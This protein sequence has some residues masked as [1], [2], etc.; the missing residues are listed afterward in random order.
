MGSIFPYA[1]D[2]ISALCDGGSFSRQLKTN[3]ATSERIQC[4]IYL[5]TVEREW[6]REM[7]ISQLNL[8]AKRLNSTRIPRGQI[9][10]C[11]GSR[12]SETRCP[13]VNSSSWSSCCCYR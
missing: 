11:N 9:A 4:Q 10:R 7:N 6:V 13:K 2:G 3:K 5:S 1:T 8:N 12:T